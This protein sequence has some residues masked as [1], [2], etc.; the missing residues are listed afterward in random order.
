MKRRLPVKDMILGLSGL[1]QCPLAIGTLLR[2]PG[3]EA[4]DDRCSSLLDERA[5][6]T[7]SELNTFQSVAHQTRAEATDARS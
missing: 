5:W 3:P 4:P 1:T 7:F 6:G 2:S